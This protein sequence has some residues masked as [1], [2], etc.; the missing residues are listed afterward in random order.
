MPPPRLIALIVALLG[1]GG[2]VVTWHAFVLS[3]DGQRLDAAAFTGAAYGQ[4]TLWRLAE[5]VLD[6]VSLGFVVVA[7][8]ATMLL[9]V[10]RSRW[11]L[12]LQVAVLVVGANITTQLLKHLVLER[13]ELGPYPGTNTLPSG[14]TT[15]AASVSMAILLVVPRRSRPFVAILGAGYT[16]ATG[17][18]TMVGQWHR[19]SDVMAAILVVLAWTGLVCALTPRSELDAGGSTATPTAVA[20]LTLAV[21]A[22]LA[23][24]SGYAVLSGADLPVVGTATASDPDV[25]A[26]V[27]TAAVVVAVTAASFAAALPLRQ[28]TATVTQ[29]T[30]A[31]PAPAPV[32]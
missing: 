24:V 18:A 9:A 25:R 6:V 7:L 16:A 12:A 31:T 29:R 2:L 19:P 27:A 15:V 14:H 20:S 23:A 32:R 3:P 1:V 4:G 17:V 11:G 26:Y 30:P 21:A 10:L 22:V 13:P 8:G 5:P 28:A